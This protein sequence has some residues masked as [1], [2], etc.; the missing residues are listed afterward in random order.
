MT[1][2]GRGCRA[3]AAGARRWICPRFAGAYVPGSPSQDPPAAPSASLRL[4]WPL[5]LPDTIA[6]THLFDKLH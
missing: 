1:G 5:V 4:P 3:G 2:G 6:A